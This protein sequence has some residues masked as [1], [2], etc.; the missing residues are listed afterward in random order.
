M[1]SSMLPVI[2]DMNDEKIILIPM[3]VR[4]TKLKGQKNKHNQCHKTIKTE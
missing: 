1:P 2:T 4:S 3:I